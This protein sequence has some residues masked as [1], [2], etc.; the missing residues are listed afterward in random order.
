MSSQN[1][2]Q[3]ALQSHSQRLDSLKAQLILV[4]QELS[5]GVIG[6]L[7]QLNDEKTYIKSQLYKYYL[8]KKSVTKALNNYGHQN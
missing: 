2:L 3:A 8:A 6:T 7:T 5:R 4:E 1:T